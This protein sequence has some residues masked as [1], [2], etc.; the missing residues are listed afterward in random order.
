[1]KV[2]TRA[3][4]KKITDAAANGGTLP[5]SAKGGKKRKAAAATEGD[6]AETPVKKGRGRKKK[7]DTPVE[8]E[9]VVSY[10]SQELY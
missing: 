6:D 7:A 10:S 3:T 8:G 1:M 5:A 2:M 9:F 4:L